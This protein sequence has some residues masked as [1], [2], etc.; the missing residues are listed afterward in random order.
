MCLCSLFGPPSLAGLCYLVWDKGYRRTASVAAA[1]SAATYLTGLATLFGSYRV[2]SLVVFPHFDAL[3]TTS[4]KTSVNAMGEPLKIQTW[5]QF[6]KLAGP[7][8]VSRAV[9]V[10]LSFYAAGV[11]Q[12]YF[13]QRWSGP[14]A[15]VPM[16][17]ARTGR[18]G[19]RPTS[20]G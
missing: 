5:A 16:P 19:T 13:A 6:Y 18:R 10:I 2:Q 9:G 7:P 8:V 12:G 3:G 11:A 17:A 15:A 4:W 1:Q 20:S 14:A